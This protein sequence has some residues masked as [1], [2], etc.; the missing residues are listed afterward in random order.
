M[1]FLAWAFV[2][3]SFAS[4]LPADQL[5]SYVAG[6]ILLAAAPRTAMVLS[7]VS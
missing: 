7:G 6:L 3:H 4:V 5:D 2:R 1:A